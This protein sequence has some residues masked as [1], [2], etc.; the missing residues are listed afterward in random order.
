MAVAEASHARDAADSNPSLP[1]SLPPRP[2]PCFPRSLSSVFRRTCLHLPLSPSPPPPFPHSRS[3][4][5][6][7]SHP[8]LQAYFIPSAASH[9]LFCF[10]LPA[11]W[12]Q[13][14]TNGSVGDFMTDIADAL[15]LQFDGIVEFI[16]S[17]TTV[18]AP[19]AWV[20]GGRRLFSISRGAVYCRRRSRRSRR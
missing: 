17:L 15:I 4:R 11:L 12:A 6:I 10:F 20:A 1:P 3:D 14:C 7:Q 19:L 9:F 8:L 13:D 2:R 16:T 5:A 18:V